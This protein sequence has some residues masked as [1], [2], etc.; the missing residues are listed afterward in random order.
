[1]TGM[2]R[3]WED[4]GGARRAVPAE[5]SSSGRKKGKSKVALQEGLRGETW[6]LRGETRLLSNNHLPL[7]GGGERKCA[8]GL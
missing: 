6:G 5:A 4:G 2:Q 8:P 7:F 1:M 3:A